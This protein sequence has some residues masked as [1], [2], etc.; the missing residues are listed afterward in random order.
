MT[1]APYP[2][3]VPVPQMRLGRSAGKSGSCSAHTE[4]T[5]R[6]T[7]AKLSSGMLNS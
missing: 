1:Q 3:P 2:E 6:A 4:E 7:R 5:G